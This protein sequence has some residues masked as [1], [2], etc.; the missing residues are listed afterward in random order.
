MFGAKEDKYSKVD[1]VIGAEAEIKGNLVSKATVRVDGKIEGDVHCEGD[2]VVGNE[3]KIKGDIKAKGIVMGG[4][5]LGNIYAEIKV[6]VLEGGQVVGDIKAPTVIIAEGGMF[7]GHC[8]MVG[9][10]KSKIVE[11]PEKETRSN[12]RSRA[13]E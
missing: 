7:E 9:K 11:I 10:E 12:T 3:G 8:E 1:S 2:V 6:E 4:K 13:S 5:I